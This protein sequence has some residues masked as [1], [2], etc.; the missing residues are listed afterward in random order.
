MDHNEPRA[1]SPRGSSEWVD[2]VDDKSSVQ[3]RA[4]SYLTVQASEVG[5]LLVAQRVD[6]VQDRCFEGGYESENKAHAG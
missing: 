6:G 3:A 2:A 1:L 5:H 4:C